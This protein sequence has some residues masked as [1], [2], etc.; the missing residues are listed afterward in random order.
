M[1]TDV[2]GIRRCPHVIL[3]IFC[4]F[5][6]GTTCHAEE[7]TGKVAAVFD[8][9]T[10]DVYH[11]GVKE[12]IRLNGIDCPEK[13]QPFGHV[14]R[15]FTYDLVHGK[16]V[17]VR[18][19]GEDKYGRTIGNVIGTEGVNL[20]R[21]LI[22]E[23]LAW[24]YWSHSTDHELEELETEAWQAKR[25]LWID[26]LPIPPWVFRKIERK[27]VPEFSDFQRPGTQKLGLLRLPGPIFA[28]KR[29]HVYRRP[30]C[31]GYARMSGDNKVEFGTIEEA[32]SA[33]FHIA[34]DCH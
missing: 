8:G 7:F 22:R 15:Q 32:E 10:I 34:K 6:I 11:D 13:G 1:V 33:G 2:Q 9:D 25:G 12:R 4:L 18:T 28:N 23:G 17:T 26:R 14:A 31:R 20:N 21:E 29:S 16:E 5:I 27:Q 24:W 19:F 3:R 30:D